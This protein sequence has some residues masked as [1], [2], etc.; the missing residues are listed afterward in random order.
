MKLAIITGGSRG[1]GKSLVNR[2]MEAGSRVVEFSRRGT[3][4]GS[5]HC[6]FSDPHNAP[7]II[8]T[9]FRSLAKT[10]YSE[11]I[12]I[13]NAGIVNPIG[14]ISEFEPNSRVDNI[15]INL[16]SAITVSGLFIKHFQNHS[17]NKVLGSISSGAAT[18][19]KDSVADE[20]LSKSPKNGSKV[21]LGD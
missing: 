17:G 3:F 8:D 20:I 16:I 19:A 9:T 12:L 11:I 18:R 21:S 1:L 6:D 2:Y 15:N 13:N 7:G 4:D 5:V 10:D 14:P